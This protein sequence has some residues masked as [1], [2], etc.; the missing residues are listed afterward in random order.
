MVSDLNVAKL[1]ATNAQVMNHLPQGY[2]V[3]TDHEVFI[4]TIVYR[5]FSSVTIMFVSAVC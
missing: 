3:R 1:V 5:L 2:D 4:L